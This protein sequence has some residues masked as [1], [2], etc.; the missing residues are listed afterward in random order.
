M[1]LD[2]L[3]ELMKTNGYNKN[4]LAKESGIPYTTIVGFYSKG[5]DNVKLSTLRK[6]ADFFGVSLDY[7][8]NGEKIK[9]PLSVSTEELT[10]INQYRSLNST[11]Q[12]ML[13]EHASMMTAS[14]LYNKSDNIMFVA[15]RNGKPSEELPENP[16][17]F[18]DAPDTI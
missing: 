2:I 6:L 18:P 3:N 5:T 7:L 16:E 15:A 1:F 17:E 12:R 8:I 13:M 9:T 10:L 4:S 14:G 11:G